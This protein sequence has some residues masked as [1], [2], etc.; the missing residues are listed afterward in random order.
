M[1][2]KCLP[3]LITIG[4]GKEMATEEWR[5]EMKGNTR[6]S[7]VIADERIGIGSKRRRERSARSTLIGE[8]IIDRLHGCVWCSASYIS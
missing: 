8:G 1:I 6:F 3:P 5:E 2:S 7:D 4:K